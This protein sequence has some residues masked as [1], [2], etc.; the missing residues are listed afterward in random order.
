MRRDG[1]PPNRWHY[2]RYDVI[3]GAY[4]F[5]LQ[6]V[7]NGK[8]PLWWNEDNFI[9]GFSTLEHAEIAIDLLKN[10][11]GTMRDVREALFALAGF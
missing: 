6:V 5:G 9:G 3:L 7:S 1:Y 8:N 10:G 11:H 4:G 2:G